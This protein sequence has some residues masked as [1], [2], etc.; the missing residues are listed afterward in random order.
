MY[1]T[2]RSYSGGAGLADA[3]VAHKD[4]V[5]ELISTIDG[6]RAYYLL[7]TTD[8][9]TTISVFADQEGAQAS[10]AAAAKWLAENLADVSPGSPQV[11]AGE[12]ALSF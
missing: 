11:T 8:G 12:V 4:E 7:R 9:A 10:N 6:F 1:A 5:R 3:L 2:I